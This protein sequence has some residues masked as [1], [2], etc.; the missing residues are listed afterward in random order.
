M[1]IVVL[2]LVT[3]L[4]FRSERKGPELEAERKTA[5]AL[6]QAKAALLG[7]SATNKSSGGN[8]HPGRLLCPNINTAPAVAGNSS[9]LSGSNCQ[10]AGAG[11]PS[12]MGRF[13]WKSLKSD[14]LRDG[15]SER[16]WYV[17]DPA[18]VNNGD[19]MN[20][21]ISPTLIVNGGG[22]VVA[23]I[24]AP[25]K[26]LGALNQQ[27]DTANQGNYQNYL[28]SYVSAL[29]INLNAPSETHNDFVITITARELFTVV[30]FRMARELSLTA[31]DGTMGATVESI[32]NKPVVWLTNQWDAAVD[33][34]PNNTTGPSGV[35]TTGTITLK[36]LNCNITYTITGPGNVVRNA[37][38]C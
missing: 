12:N 20:S 37:P 26:A 16:L 28:E 18:F 24:F 29:A 4:T 5:L 7:N 36:F 21:R 2:G 35:S 14:D 3:L 13:P 1:L 23:A 19:E 31:Y 15:A 32:D 9:G 25:G 11:I 17:V 38:T 6:A 34:P 27:R 22:Q 30:T 33:G 8:E 10:S